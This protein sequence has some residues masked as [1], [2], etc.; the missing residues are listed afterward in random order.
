MLKH[1]TKVRVKNK[2]KQLNISI[3]QR[4]DNRIKIRPSD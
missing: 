1:I 4:K 2:F 3:I